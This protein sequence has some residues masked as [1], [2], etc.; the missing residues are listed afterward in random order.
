MS[1]CDI[2]GGD[3]ESNKATIVSPQEMRIIAGNGYGRNIKLGVGLSPEERRQKFY[4]LAM[5]NNTPWALCPACYQK[6]RSYAKESSSGPSEEQFREM[7]IEPLLKAMGDKA[8]QM[9]K[10]QKTS[11]VNKPLQ[12]T[13]GK[14]TTLSFIIACIIYFIGFAIIEGRTPGASDALGIVPIIIIIVL[15]GVVSGILESI[16]KPK[17]Q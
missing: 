7:A 9:T 3:V 14:I 17:K 12:K 4:E 5:V 11:P 8:P 16:R 10:A 6:T 1:T 15:W 13:S 2:C